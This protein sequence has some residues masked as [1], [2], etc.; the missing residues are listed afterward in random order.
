DAGYC[1]S[2]HTGGDR[3]VQLRKLD[4]HGLR[5]IFGGRIYVHQHKNTDALERVLTTIGV[6]R[7]D[8]W[9]V[10]NSTRSDIVPALECGIGAIY[11]PP[12]TTWAYDAM[13]EPPHIPSDRWLCVPRLRDVVGALAEQRQLG[14]VR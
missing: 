13:H 14:G 9:M 12:L 2:L 6:D 8:T 10:G 1:L 4:R 5:D 7:S 3:A 11:V